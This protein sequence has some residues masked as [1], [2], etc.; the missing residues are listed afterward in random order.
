MYI[1]LL[2]FLFIAVTFFF[3]YIHIYN[4][5]NQLAKAKKCPLQEHNITKQQQKLKFFFTR[6]KTQFNENRTTSL[7]YFLFTKLTRLT[8]IIIIFFLIIR[9]FS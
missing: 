6:S 1:N 9:I 2:V 7:L 3:F 8:L 5:I 4:N